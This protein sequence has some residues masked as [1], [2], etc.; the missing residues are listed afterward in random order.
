[1][2]KPAAIISKGFLLQS[3]TQPGVITEKIAI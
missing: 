2:H 3:L 1:M